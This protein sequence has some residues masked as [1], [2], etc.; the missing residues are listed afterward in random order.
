MRTRRPEA[1]DH[2]EYYGRY[3]ALVADGDIV[4]TLE[5]QPATTRRIL[6]G[7]T[8][9]QERFRYAPGKWSVR[10]SMGHLVDT[11]RV[12]TQRLLWFARGAEGALPGMDQDAWAATAGADARPL[13]DQLAEWAH[14]RGGVVALLK[15]LGDDAWD[16]SGIASGVHFTVRSL[17]W[18]IAGHELHHRRLFTEAY[19]LG[20]AS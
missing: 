2:A 8:E 17:P 10:E 18:I 20:S 1:G 11:E 12:F 4:E 9:A 5:S 16:R 6:S 7:L 15:G 14:V 13:A 3:V 19:G